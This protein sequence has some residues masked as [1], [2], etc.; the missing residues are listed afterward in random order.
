MRKSLL[1]EWAV[2]NYYSMLLGECNAGS[3]RFAY[4][5]L[6][7]SLLTP[8]FCP[9]IRKLIFWLTFFLLHQY[10]RWH[11]SR[12]VQLLLLTN[13]HLPFQIHLDHFPNQLVNLLLIKVS[14]VQPINLHKPFQVV[15]F[16]S[17][18]FQLLIHLFFSLY[19]SICTTTLSFSFWSTCHAW[20]F[21]IY[22]PFYAATFFFSR[23]SIYCTN[24]WSYLR[25]IVLLGYISITK[26]I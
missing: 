14:H 12:T 25:W 16:P 7:L 22:W 11:H 21:V 20:V 3:T 2:L 1:K 23:W 9:K 15:N 13:F 18:A 5:I 4:T 6:N 10:L 24:K 17:Q 26:W 8:S 19:Q